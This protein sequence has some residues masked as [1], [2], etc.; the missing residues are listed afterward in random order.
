MQVEVEKVDEDVGEEEDV[1]N[2]EDVDE[3]FEGHG[4]VNDE[5]EYYDEYE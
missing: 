3:E 2:E 1:G 5:E 4:N